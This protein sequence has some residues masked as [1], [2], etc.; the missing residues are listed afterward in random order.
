M[1]GGQVGIAGHIKLA[2][3]TSVGAQSGVLKP[4]T[5]GQKIFGSIGFDLN[6]WLRSYTVFKKLPNMEQRLKELEKKQNS[7]APL[8]E[9]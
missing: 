2:N 9:K 6:N 1:I 7:Q 8:K 4:T 5:E 3:K